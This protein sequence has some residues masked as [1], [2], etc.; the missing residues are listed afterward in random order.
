MPAARPQ[1]HDLVALLV[2][3]PEH[4]LSAGDTGAVVHCYPQAEA[5]EVEFLDAGGKTKAVATLEGHQIL[6]LN[7]APVNIP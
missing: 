5:F 7:W 4:D 6:K 3:I 2:D 1:E